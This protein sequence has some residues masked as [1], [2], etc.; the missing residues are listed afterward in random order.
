MT[1]NRSFARDVIEGAVPAHGWLQLFANSTDNPDPAGN[2]DGGTE[3]PP[4]VKTYTEEEVQARVRQAADTAAA[5]ARRALEAEYKPKLSEATDALAAARPFLDNPVGYMSRYLAQNPG[6]LQAVADGVDRIARGLAPTQQQ[7]AAV[8]RAA[9]DAGDPRVAKKLETLQAEM[10]ATREAVDGERTLTAELKV[11]AKE[12]QADGLDW[13][14]DGFRDFVNTYADENEIGDDDSIDTRLMFRL[15][16]AE[17]KLQSGGR[18]RPPKLP[19]SNAGTPNAQGNTRP[20]SWE[21][22]GAQ[23][24]ARLKAAQQD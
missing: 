21:D 20:K 12:A 1:T 18:P 11:F 3:Q 6:D 14:E 23:A 8:G 17:Q 19:G 15:W 4:A 2:P 10:T 5:K 7:I 22:A 9:D 24:V 16:K 13:D